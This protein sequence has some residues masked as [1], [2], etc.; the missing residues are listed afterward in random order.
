VH[1]V[2]CEWVAIDSHFALV[3]MYPF[4]AYT[5]DSDC[6]SRWPNLQVLEVSGVVSL[7][8]ISV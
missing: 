5:N 7:D 2:H 6:F 8:L 1:C 3:Q 4:N